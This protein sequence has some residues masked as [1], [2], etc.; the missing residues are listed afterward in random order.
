MQATNV[1]GKQSES[2]PE[3]RSPKSYDFGSEE[4]RLR[5]EKLAASFKAGRT[6]ET[7]AAME[8]MEQKFW[9]NKFKVLN[10]LV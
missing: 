8:R 10:E 9:G 2:K 3:I 6:P 7:D 5:R 1:S 4:R